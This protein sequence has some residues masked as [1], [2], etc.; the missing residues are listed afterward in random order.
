M[1]RKVKRM[2]AVFTAFLM[3]LGVFAAYI[4]TMPAYA[5]I[6]KDYVALDSQDPV[7]FNGDTVVYGGETITLGPKAYILTVS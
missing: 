4:P 3:V 7:Q 1:R 6:G 2:T 5:G